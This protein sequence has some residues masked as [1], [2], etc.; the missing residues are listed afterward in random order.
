MDSSDG[1]WMHDWNSTC[2]CPYPSTLPGCMVGHVKSCIPGKKPVET[3]TTNMERVGELGA[4]NSKLQIE[5]DSLQQ[6]V[7][8]INIVLDGDIDWIDAVAL[9]CVVSHLEEEIDMM[10]FQKDLNKKEMSN[11]LVQALPQ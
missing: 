7:D 11:L 9:S 1:V 3:R 4:L 5:I 2:M 10:Q 6:I 8:N